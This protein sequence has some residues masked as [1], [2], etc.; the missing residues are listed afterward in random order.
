[1]AKKQGKSI[2]NTIL[3]VSG[4]PLMLSDDALDEFT[5]KVR[6][7]GNELATNARDLDAPRVL[8]KALIDKGPDAVRGVLEKA[9]AEAAKAKA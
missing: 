6:L 5:A 8:E 7:L 3:E 9:L 4:I 2:A 1:M